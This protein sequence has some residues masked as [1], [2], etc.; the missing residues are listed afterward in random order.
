MLQGTGKE[1]K[2]DNGEENKKDD[3]IRAR[4]VKDEEMRRLKDELKR[5]M[6]AMN[7]KLKA[8]ADD[9]QRKWARKAIASN[10]RDR[11][12]EA[13]EKEGCHVDEKKFGDKRQLQDVHDRRVPEATTSVMSDNSQQPNAAAE[14]TSAENTAP[15]PVDTM[16]Y[17]DITMTNLDMAQ[18]TD[19]DDRSLVNFLLGELGETHE[20][21]LDFLTAS[22]DEET[23]QSLDDVMAGGLASLGA[24]NT[25]AL[26]DSS[27]A[28]S[29]R[30][31]QPPQDMEHSDSQD[32]MQTLAPITLEAWD[33]TG[34]GG[35]SLHKPKVATRSLHN[36]LTP[37]DIATLHTPQ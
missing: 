33:S 28:G 14:L 18:L 7:A 5:T 22:L 19:D 17:H 31:S 16:P 24:C 1:K 25:G 37:Q 12:S 15:T 36:P 3:E 23:I 21:Y 35:T 27:G 26:A 30:L 6:E 13:V 34:F 20:A 10:A 11:V 2:E 4:V 9:V 32:V 29:S 8:K